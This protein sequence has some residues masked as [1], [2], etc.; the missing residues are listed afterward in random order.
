MPTTET[1]SL[2]TKSVIWTPIGRVSFAQ[3]FPPRESEDINKK[4]GEYDLTW[5]CTLLCD[6]EAPEMKNIKRMEKLLIDEKF[7]GKKPHNY[8]P[9]Y[10]DGNTF[11]LDNENY[12]LYA[13]KIVIA[14][15]SKN[16]EVIPHRR[17]GQIIDGKPELVPCTKENFFSGVWAKAKIGMYAYDFQG[18]KGIACGLRN[19]YLVKMDEPLGRGKRNAVKDL[20]DISDIDEL[21][22]IDNGALIGSDDEDEEYDY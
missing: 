21:E 20:E 5:E 9:P 19:I 4:T 14:V 3:F 2:T 1:K 17:T 15:R 16:Q 10:R 12:K 7:K 6:P 8:K 22:V 11:D 18:S 13:Y